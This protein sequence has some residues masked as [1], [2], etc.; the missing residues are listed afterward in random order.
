LQKE[1]SVQLKSAR[2]VKKYTPLLVARQENCEADNLIFTQRAF[3]DERL[4]DAFPSS[5][6]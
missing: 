2:N 4:P 5:F 6:A 1:K 3:R